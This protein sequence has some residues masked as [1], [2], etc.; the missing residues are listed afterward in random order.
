MF[1][2]SKKATKRAT[3]GNAGT[4]SVGIGGS[5]ASLTTNLSIDTSR[6]QE[7]YELVDF[8]NRLIVRRLKN[9]NSQLKIK[10]QEI[11]CSQSN[12]LKRKVECGRNNY[13]PMNSQETAGRKKSSGRRISYYP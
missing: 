10:I 5:T 12:N 4:T 7:K 9:E 13:R 8:N 3:R 1:S 2:T 6:V 11:E